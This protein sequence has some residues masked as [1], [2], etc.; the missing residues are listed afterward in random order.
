MFEVGTDGVDLDHGLSV[1]LALRPRGE[2][3]VDRLERHIEDIS[4]QLQFKHFL[5]FSDWVVQVS[6]AAKNRRSTK[7]RLSR[8]L[9]YQY[10]SGS[11]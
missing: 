2:G 7:I 3:I 9:P 1:T 10:I 8:C 5:S 6:T 11:L 4:R